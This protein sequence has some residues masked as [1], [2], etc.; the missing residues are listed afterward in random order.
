MTTNKPTSVQGLAIGE[1]SQDTLDKLASRDE[2]IRNSG[3][4]DIF[5]QVLP[6][7]PAD[8][9]LKSRDKGY[10]R[11]MSNAVFDLSVEYPV[12]RCGRIRTQA[13]DLRA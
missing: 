8:Y 13:S 7:I 3:K 11:D 5:Q 9:V 4:L 1:V 6:E 12:M 10:F 2:D